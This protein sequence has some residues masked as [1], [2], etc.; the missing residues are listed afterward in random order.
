MSAAPPPPATAAPRAKAAMRL[1]PWQAMAL[2]GLLAGGLLLAAWPRLPGWLTTLAPAPPAMSEEARRAGELGAL[3]VALRRAATAEDAQKIEADI[4]IRLTRSVS[5]GVDLLLES[6]A[7]AQEAGDLDAARA[8]L[9]DA[10]EL[11]PDFAEART[12]LAAVAYA[13]GDLE[14]ARAQLRRATRLEPRH[15][16][17]WV[18][19]G[20]VLEDAGDLSGAAAAYEEAL[21]LHPLLDVAKRGLLRV[22]AKTDGLAM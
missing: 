7:A 1:R 8:I 6:A 18:G 22:E 15:F 4:F 20:T 16:A 13:Q 21:F 19:L 2:G 17:A 11:A 9:T 14:A 12:R 3:F 10:V 5:P